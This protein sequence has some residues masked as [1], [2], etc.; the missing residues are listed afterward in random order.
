MNNMTFRLTALAIISIFG[1]T[2]SCVDAQA[3]DPE[4]FSAIREARKYI[5]LKKSYDPSE[6]QE[7]FTDSLNILAANWH[8]LPAIYQREFQGIF[9]R[10]GAPGSLF[11]SVYLP[12]KYDTPHFRLH[13]TTVGHHA[14]PPDDFNPMNGV[15]DYVDICADALERSYHVQIELMGYKAP[16]DDFWV[17][18]NGGNQKYDVYLFMFPAL[19]ITVSSSSYGRV[20]STVVTTAPWF[21]INSR[22]HLYFGKSEAV[23]FIETTCAHEFFHGVQYAY[24]A[25]MPTWFMEASA[26]WSESKVYDG[27]LID[28]LDDIA[29]PDEIGETN[30]YNYYSGQLRRWFLQPDIAL[31]NRVGDHEYGSVIFVFYMAE[32]FGVDIV[33]QF[34]GGATEGS[35][36]EYGNFEG[37]FRNYGTTLVEAF[38]TF[39][40]WN[41]FT[42]NRDDGEHYFNG[43]RFPPVAIHPSD[44]HQRYPVRIDFD[45]ESMPEPFSARY[46]VFEPD[47]VMNEFAVK[48]DGADLAPMDMNELSAGDRDAIQGELDR[49]EATGLRGWGAKFAVEKRDGTTEVREALTYHRSQEAQI[50]FNDF[51]GEIQKVTLILINVRPDVERVVVEGG[52]SVSGRFISAAFGGSVSYMA[53]RPPAGVLSTPTVSQGSEG[54]VLVQWTLEDLSG[55]RE[56]AIVRKRYTSIYDT[57]SPQPFQNAA[58]VLVAADRDGNGIPEGDIN[59][60]GRVNAT[61]TSFEDVTIFQDIDVEDSRFDPQNIRYFYAVVPVNAVGLM[62]RPGIDAQ[63]ITPAFTPLNTTAAPPLHTRLL[64]SYPNPFNPDVWIPYELAE[65]S[66]VSIEIYDISGALVRTLNLGVKVRGR[67]IKQGEAAHWDGRTNTGVRAASSVYFYSL[68]TGSSFDTQ[69]MVITK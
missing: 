18:V 62:G 14:P 30:A 6:L 56:V 49:H 48:V 23:R 11:G 19:G 12:N 59:I 40:E 7:C 29:D 24:N 64:Q 5:N 57:D 13:Y 53:G 27:G 35:Y 47:G 65:D 37:V 1:F 43:H 66:P 9:L 61:D 55:I 15:P 32:R 68:R 31:R 3:P 69:K 8:H 52:R 34:Y 50:T 58:E 16:L 4:L 28:D 41:Y 60:I 38:K 46:I 17:K 36:R 22:M 39:T 51:G 26:T 45:S 10:P 44:V 63:G 42:H 25:L 20:L 54:G 2:A 33:R 67:Y 21:G